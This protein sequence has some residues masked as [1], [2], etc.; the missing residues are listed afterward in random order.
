[1]KG[2]GAYFYLKDNKLDQALQSLGQAKDVYSVFLRSFIFL[3]KKDYKSAYSNLIQSLTP[4]T[5]SNIPYL[6]FL[7]R[8]CNQHKL[9]EL[10]IALIDTILKEKNP[11]DPSALP[12][13]LYVGDVLESLDQPEQALKLY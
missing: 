2:I 1:M 10:S 4:E 11:Q 13:L 8:A 5:K 12:L 7:I 3:A 9:P 6:Q